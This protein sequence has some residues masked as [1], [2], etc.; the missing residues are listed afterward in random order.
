MLIDIDRIEEYLN[1]ITTIKSFTGI[2][3]TSPAFCQVSKYAC[4]PILESQ[5]PTL[6][7]KYQG[8][9]SGFRDLCKKDQ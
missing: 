5:G 2:N 8:R 1:D 4:T 7:E 3:R 9:H 6:F